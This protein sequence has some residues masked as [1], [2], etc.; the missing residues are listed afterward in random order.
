MYY[1]TSPTSLGGRG[2]GCSGRLIMAAAIAIFSIISYFGTTQNN[3]ITGETQHISITPE[4]ETALGLQAVPEMES[5]FGGEDAN[6]NDQ[7]IV[8]QVGNN[9]LQGSSAGNAPYQFDFHLLA[10]PQTINA[11]ALPGGQVFITR[12][13]Y[14]KLQTEGEL[15][16]VLGHEIGHVVARHSAEQI[17]KTQLT[18]G[19]T[20]A[21]VIAAYDPNNPSSAQSAQIAALIGQLVTLKFS[22]D[23][24]LEADK[25]GVCFMNE[26]GHDPNEMISVMQILEASQTGNQ[27]PEFFSTHPN[28][29]NRIQQIQSDIQNVSACP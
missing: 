1:R 29:G 15:A 10:D 22:R 16:S 25:F 18:E 8:D 23:D 24:E 20:G 21:A 9:I 17:A 2:S 6:A 12:A 5:Q 28:P 19:L 4:Q 13:L 27:P 3:P 26:A 14:E 7:A 11:F